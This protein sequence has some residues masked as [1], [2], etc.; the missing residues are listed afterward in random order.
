MELTLEQLAKDITNIDLNDILECWRWRLDKMQAV[1]TISVL[2]D[3]FLLGNDGA[4][5]WL[6]TD[7]GEL[8]KIADTFEQY[9]QFLIDDE[10]IDNWFL[11]SLVEKLLATGKTLKENQVYS[12]K[13]LPVIGGEYTVDNIEPTDMSVHFA[14]SGQIC[15][16]IK[17]LPNGTKVNIKV[18][19]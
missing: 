11:P 1:V 17:D 13:K 6:Q 2:G 19:H 5:Y 16:H 8:T 14:F 12:Y 18:E 4:V 15:E 3:I 7:S 10:K 9:Q